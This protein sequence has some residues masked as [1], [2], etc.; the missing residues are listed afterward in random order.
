MDMNT[1]TDTSLRFS[2]Q[3]TRGKIF[4]ILNLSVPILMGIFIFFN[5]FPHT[6]SIKE[7]CFYLSAFIVLALVIFK[8]TEFAFTTPLLLPV[9][10]F[11]FWAFL[12]I[13]FAF[14]KD[15]SIHDFYSHLIRYIIL[16]YIMTNFFSSKKALIN[17]SW[18]IIISSSIFSTAAIFY[19]YH[20]SG[21][22]LSTR[23]AAIGLE[24]GLLTQ[25]PV[26]I[27]GMITVFAIIL[28]M[29]NLITEAHFFPRVILI[30][31]L[32]SLST[33]IFLTQTRSTIMAVVLGA[34]V[35]LFKHK[36]IMGVVI[37]MIFLVIILTP[38]KNR[39]SLNNILKNE[40][41]GINYI[42][43]E[44]IK[45]HP[46]IGIGFGLQTYGN[47]NLNGY[48]QLL[49]AKYKSKNII[50]DPHNML[51]DIAV[52]LGLVG[53]AFF[54]Y[55]IFSFFK[56]CL[57]CIKQGKDVFI[58]KWG[59]CMASACVAFLVIGFFQPIFSHMLEVILCTIFS[60]ITVLWRINKA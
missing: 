35:L 9:G 55:I 29:H 39:F 46:I 22:A 3:N 47:A 23:F 38:L 32:L 40:R 49:P 36:K 25:T 34:I 41:I 16:F 14:D 48:N 1:T 52:R 53:L 60:L 10:L 57:V 18:I 4:K 45:D 15:N 6:T 50:T 54:L 59:R 31:C 43:L 8:K 13:F 56:M 19:F 51:L 5:P 17:L 42:T 58:K 33:A 24:S 7:I 28:A 11:A 44:I 2:K 27:I 26:N 12:S 20:I 30:L 37:G 21:N